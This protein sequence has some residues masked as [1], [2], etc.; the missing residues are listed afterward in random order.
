M[1]I[2]DILHE[3]Q[4]VSLRAQVVLL[5]GLPKPAGVEGSQ[6]RYTP[7]VVCDSGPAYAIVEEL[8]LGGEDVGVQ[9]Q[10]AGDQDECLFT[11]VDIN[12]PLQVAL[13]GVETPMGE[14]PPLG[15]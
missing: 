8:L 10:V 4:Q 7:E 6:C 3:L 2:L 1:L 9:V 15:L 14:F 13:V 12:L 5:T 11:D